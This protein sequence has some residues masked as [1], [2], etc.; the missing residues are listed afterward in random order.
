VAPLL[1]A[2]QKQK[3]KVWN[4]TDILLISDGRFPM[5]EHVIEQINE[6]KSSQGLCLHGLLLGDWRSPAMQA[7]CEPL[8]FFDSWGAVVSNK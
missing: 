7:V 4:K 1:K 2:I 8:Y 5:Q 3:Q 6:L